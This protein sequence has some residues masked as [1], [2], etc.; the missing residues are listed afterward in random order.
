MTRDPLSRDTARAFALAIVLTGG[1]MLAACS[2]GK[3]PAAEQLGATRSSVEAAQ[4]AGASD[5]ASP[6]M[7]KAREKLAQAE[8]ASRA[9]DNVRARQL[10][11]EA[12]VDAL[13]ARSKA[14]SDRSQKAAAELDASLAT[15]RDEMTRTTNKQ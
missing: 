13:V 8:A 9:K 11:E 3:V 2:T 5:D 1:A 14:A 4:V 10:A 7:A 15:L 12:E 6:E